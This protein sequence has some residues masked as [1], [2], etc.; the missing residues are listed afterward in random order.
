MRFLFVS[1]FGV[2]FVCLFVCWGLRARR[3]RGHFT[4]ISF[5]GFG[6]GDHDYTHFTPRVHSR[7]NPAFSAFSQSRFSFLSLKRRCM[8]AVGAGE[9]AAAGAKDEGAPPAGW[10]RPR[11]YR[12]RVSAK[13]ERGGVRGS[14]S[15][16]ETTSH[17]GTQGHIGIRWG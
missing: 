4:P 11:P 3:R 2:L 6:R 7:E 13:E 12:F 14:D 15:P 16:G 9:G 8:V 1:L 17:R 10:Y 5:G